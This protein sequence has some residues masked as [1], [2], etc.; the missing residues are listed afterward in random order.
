MTPTPTP[1]PVDHFQCFKA[2]IAHG[3]P[4]FT[5]S[6]GV[7]L[8]DHFTL[9]GSTTGFLTVD[10]KKANSLCNPA[11]I[12]GME[13]S[14][15]GHTE[16]G[17]GYQIKIAAHT[18]PFV[19]VLNTQVYNPDFGL[20]H[21]NVSK[22][23]G[24][25]VPSAKSLVSSPPPILAPATDHFA[26]Y[27]AKTTAGTPRFV[28]VLGVTVD[29]QFG[30][31]M[32]DVKKPVQLCVPANVNNQEPGAQNDAVVLL[33]YKTKR[34]GNV[35]KFTPL[36]PVYVNNDFGPLTLTAVLNNQVCV[37]AVILP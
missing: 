22:P 8:V 36:T 35:P 2:G 18:T 9:I 24:L 11:D 30:P 17:V 15:P 3:A 13:P 21:L 26:C 7:T 32:V 4:K 33:C 29:D 14:A 37:P 20:L 5:P 25:F 1:F 28:P 10:V 34:P 12:N 27:K 6:P 23:V 16:H 31:R 19:K